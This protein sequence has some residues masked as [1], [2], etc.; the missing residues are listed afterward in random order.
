VSH[1][2]ETRGLATAGISLVREQT[3][4]M[5][6]PRFLWVPF[7]LGRPFGAPNEPEFQ[8]RVL[9][10]VLALFD[11]TD[12]P[13]VLEDFQ[14]DA[15]T[16]DADL[17][18]A[19]PV[20]FAP[21]TID[22]PSLHSAIRNEIASLA[23]WAEL[24]PAPAPNTGIPLDEMVDRINLITVA[25]RRAATGG[26]DSDP[27]DIERDDLEPVEIEEVRLLADDLRTWYLHAVAQQPGS[28]GS[29]ERNNWFWRQSAL[30]HL[31][32]H[33]AAALATYPDRRVQAFA[34]RG[35]VPRDHW[36]LLI[37]DLNQETSD[38]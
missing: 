38:V 15:P 6:L 34:K 29:H 17:P 9:S 11:R 21:P 14:E 31:L 2:L 37:P 35:I 20:S 12:G 3:E 10:D 18:W 27:V 32:G 8:R 24:R 13:V 25:A 22:E 1:Y 36:D 16:T 26:T 33:L 19:C 7:E 23:P 28:A 30:A 4:A 5:R